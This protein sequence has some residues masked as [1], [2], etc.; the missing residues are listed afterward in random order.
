M[1][2]KCVYT[3]YI[4]TIDLQLKHKNLPLKHM[5]LKKTKEKTNIK[6]QGI[7]P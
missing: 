2:D 3:T 5:N 1:R 7:Q 4:S 6:N